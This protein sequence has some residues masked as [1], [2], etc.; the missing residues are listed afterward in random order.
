MPEEAAPGTEAPVSVV[1]HVSPAQD[2]EGSS[3]ED[4][5]PS[6][7]ALDAERT[8][9]ED[10]TPALGDITH[11]VVTNVSETTAPE[12][13]F[14]ADVK[15]DAAP[16]TAPPEAVV[17]TGAEGSTAVYITSD[18]DNL[19]D[20]AAPQAETASLTVE[21]TTPAPANG[22]TQHFFFPV[23]NVTTTFSPSLA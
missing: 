10:T 22:T 2:K 1:T 11:E 9:H 15:P 4:L 20:S 12:K 6:E 8:P 5:A 17:D 16:E 18:V 3:V 14:V 13:P 7:V 23:V 21:E 19:P